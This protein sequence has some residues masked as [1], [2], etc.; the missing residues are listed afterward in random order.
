MGHILIQAIKFLSNPNNYFKTKMYRTEPHNKKIKQNHK[1]TI[2][3]Q[4]KSKHFYGK[5]NQ[6]HFNET[7]SISSV[8]IEILFL[9]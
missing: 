5:K 6:E 8:F 2:I 9:R 4:C 7:F 3:K 1:R